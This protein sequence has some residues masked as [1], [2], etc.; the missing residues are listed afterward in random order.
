[1]TP[2]TE[3]IIYL[4]YKELAHVIIKV[5]ESQDVPSGDPIKSIV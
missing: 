1:M 3:P 4:N 5:K 2:Q